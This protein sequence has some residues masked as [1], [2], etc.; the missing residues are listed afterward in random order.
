V[1]DTIV[2]TMPPGWVHRQLA[3]GRGLLLV[4]GVDELQTDRRPTVRTWLEDLLDT[5]PESL[6]VVTSRPP[7]SSVR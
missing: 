1:A 4:D 5:Y 3:E 2:G 7:A 6:V